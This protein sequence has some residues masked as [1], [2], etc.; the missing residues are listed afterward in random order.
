M[1]ASETTQAESKKRSNWILFL[2]IAVCAAPMILSYFTYYVI[3]PERR[4][5][6]GELIDPRRYP[7]PDL[8]ATT[9]DGGPAS[10]NDYHGKWLLIQVDQGR[11]D[12]RCTEKL[13]YMRQL[14]AAQGKERERIE[15]VWLVT[16]DAPLSTALVKE[17]DGT[18]ILRVDRDKLAKWLPVAEGARAEDHLYMIDPLG[19]L[20]MRF[21]KAPDYNKVKKDIIKL[22]RASAI[23]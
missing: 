23:G 13:Y 11:C 1:Q 3:K 12:A 22:L 4:N 2:V 19:N 6:Y 5:N 15:R 18:R 14:R 17:Y 10:L 20:M 16:D 8:G 7:I 9:L 21:P